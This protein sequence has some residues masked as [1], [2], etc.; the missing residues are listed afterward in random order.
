MSLFQCQHCGCC[1]NTALA[2]QGCRG[3]FTEEAFDWSGIEGRRGKLLCSACGPAKFASGHPSELGVWH[4]KFPRRFL[5]MDLFKTAKNGNL[6]HVET[7][8]QD[9]VKYAVHTV[10]TENAPPT[11]LG[12]GLS[13]LLRASHPEDL[14]LIVLVDSY[15]DFAQTNHPEPSQGEV[16]FGRPIPNDL[17]DS[18]K[19]VSADDLPPGPYD[20]EKGDAVL[21]PNRKP[22]PQKIT[23]KGKVARW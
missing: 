19:F 20:F 12:E 1:E 3:T 5:P 9:Y 2:H 14:V 11:V 7:G 17:Y 23:R 16:R 10:D 8:D 15:Q 6:E 4:G 18:L 13:T 21:A 22:G